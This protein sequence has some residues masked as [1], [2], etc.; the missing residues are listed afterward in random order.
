VAVLLSLASPLSAQ[1]TLHEHPLGDSI[2]WVTFSISATAFDHATSIAWS[3]RPS[4]CTEGTLSRRNADGTLNGWRAAR[5]EG[6]EAAGFLGALYIAK[7]F[8]WRLMEVVVKSVI[9]T[10]AVESTY[11]GI[12]SLAVCS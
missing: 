8:H 2:K 4:N 5:D 7:K 6:L 11:Y 10:Q 1:E 3:S 9:I 12:K